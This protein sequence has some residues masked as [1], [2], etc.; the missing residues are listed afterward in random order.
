LKE[1]LDYWRRLRLL[2]MNSIDDMVDVVV[3]TCTLH[4]ICLQAND[5]SDEIC[6]Q[7]SQLSGNDGDVPEPN[8]T[9]ATAKRDLIT[10]FLFH[11]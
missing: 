11:N 10:Q 2:D 5:T 3:A 8:E 1:L 7:N 6:D 9:C 4:N